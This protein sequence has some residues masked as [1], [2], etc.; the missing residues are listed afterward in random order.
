[1]VGSVPICPLCDWCLP[2]CTRVCVCVR[3]WVCVGVGV[4]VWADVRVYQCSL[5]TLG[6]S[7]VGGTC[8]GCPV[9]VCDC[10]AGQTASHS[11]NGFSTNGIMVYTLLHEVFGGRKGAVVE[12]LSRRHC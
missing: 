9:V 6:G 2:V 4:W 8:G 1:M 11:F 3:V 7:S 12:P 5:H 10:S